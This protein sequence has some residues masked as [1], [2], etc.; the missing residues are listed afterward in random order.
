MEGILWT[1]W[2]LVLLWS[3]I[4]ATLRVGRW[5]ALKSSPPFWKLLG[6]TAVSLACCVLWPVALAIGVALRF[7][8]HDPV[9]SLWR[10]IARLF[11]EEEDAARWRM[12]TKDLLA[13]LL[14]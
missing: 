7:D 10:R 11:G 1:V 12:T 13:E 6:I 4:S 14:A 5:L 9:E 3:L 8:G 2:G